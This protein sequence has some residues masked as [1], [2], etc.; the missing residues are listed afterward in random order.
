MEHVEYAVVGL[1]AL[2]SATAYQL[3]RRGARVIGFEQFDL[4]HV[5][6]A[7]H[8]TSRI[9]RRCYDRPEY[10]KLADSAYQDWDDFARVSGERLVTRTGGLTFCPPLGPIPVSD[11]VDSLRS[12]EVEFDVLTASDVKK[13]W[14]Q[15]ELDDDV[16]TVHSPDS[17][18]VH[19]SRSVAALQMQARVRGASLR[20]R[21]AVT[22][23]SDD[24]AGVVLQ[25]AA[26][27]VIAERVILCTDAWTNGLLEP[28][29]AAVP[30]VTM[31]EQVTYFKPSRPTEFEIGRFPVWIW[32]DDVCFYGFP[33]FG[34]T[35][36]KAARDVSNVFMDVEERSFVPS[37]SRL[38]ELTGFMRARLPGAAEPLRTITCQ[39]ALTP[40]R[41]FVIGA[42]PGHPRLFLGLGAGHAFKFTPTI[43]RM[44][45][46]LAMTDITQED[47][48]LFAA[49][50][51][52]L[53]RGSLTVSGS[54]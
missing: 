34:E 5:R 44:L 28:L 13:R 1:G 37:A 32:E 47:L 39:Y 12:I 22:G 46:D 50:R 26:G 18:I 27:P 54:I 29:G 8:D 6:G 41:H 14:P 19:A 51:P 21:C 38:E 30:L 45:A 16:L 10:V 17:G 42:V 52:A 25:T 33:F 48:S 35:T 31:Q 40:D 20:D 49:D 24:G 36:V 53:H 15:F 43:G 4:G 9:L 11:Y 23:I 2:G 7:S 3:A